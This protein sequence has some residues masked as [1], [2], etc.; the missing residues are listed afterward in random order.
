MAVIVLATNETTTTNEGRDTFVRP[1]IKL[2]KNSPKN[3]AHF[4]LFLASSFFF[5]NR[6]SDWKK[7]KNLRRMIVAREERVYDHRA[8]ATDAIRPSDDLRSN[9]RV[10]VVVQDDVCR[11]L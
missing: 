10:H 4:F 1:V 2:C 3:F 5:S 9:V 7:N 11:G 8:L 6:F